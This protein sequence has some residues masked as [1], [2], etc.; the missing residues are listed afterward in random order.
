MKDG[1]VEIESM[2]VPSNFDSINK[3]EVLID[4]VCSR[5]AVN[6][7]YYGNV[8]IAVTEAV[9]NAIQHG[10]KMS[11]DLTVDVLV[12]DKESDFCFSVNDFGNGFDFKNL[13]D[14]T[15]PENIEKENGRGI[16]LMRSLA[17][18]VEFEDEGRSVNIYFSKK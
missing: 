14:P 7:D 16:Y 15:A 13:P 12:G 10:N 4:S 9:N 11:S 3:V 2:K 8:L 18:E 1:F 6:E 17:E 5:L